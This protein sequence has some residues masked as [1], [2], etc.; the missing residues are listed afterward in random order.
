MYKKTQVIML[1]TTAVLVYNPLYICAWNADKTH[2]DVSEIAAEKSVIS[3]TFG[4]YLKR[5]GFNKST[6]EEFKLGSETRSVKKWIRQ[7]SIDEDSGSAFNGRFYNHFHDPTKAWDVAGLTSSWFW[8]KDGKSAVLWAVDDSSNDWRWAK[9]RDY[10]YYALTSTSVIDRSANFASTF[11]GLGQII[12]LIQDMAQPAHVRNDPHPADDSGWIPGLEYWGQK[13]PENVKAIA[14]STSTLIFPTVDLNVS[15]GGYAPIT[16]FFDTDQYDGTNPSNSLAQGLAEYTN[17][18][19]FSDDTIFYYAYPSKKTSVTIDEK[20]YEDFLNPGNFVK[21]QYYMKTA[22]GETGYRLA[23]VDYLNFY[24]EAYLDPTQQELVKT[25]GLMDDYVHE[26]YAKKLIPRAVGYSAGLVNYFFR[27]SLEIS[28]PDSYIYSITDGSA[29]SQ[30]FNQIKAKVKNTTSGES[31]GNGIIQAVAR[32]KNRRDYQPDLSTDPPL[33]RSRDADF[34]YSVSASIPITSLSSDTPTEFTFD[35]SGSPIPAGITDL[36]LHVVFK[37]TL[38][39]ETDNAIAVGM[40]DINEPMHISVWNATD[41][42]Y[43]DGVLRTAEEIRNDPTLLSRVD[44]NGDD[45]A[46]EYIDPYDITTKVAFAPTTTIPATY[47]AT[48]T[49]LPSGRYG[50]TIIITDAPAFYMHIHRESTIPYDNYN[51]YLL[52]SGVTNQENNGIFDNTQVYTFRGVTQHE[53][54]AY[55]RYYPYSTGISTAPW[56]APADIN[57]YPAT[58]IYP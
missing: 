48:Y 40:K 14:S 10:Y 25:I 27:G 47:N 45:T 21:R 50:R 1:L 22:D 4:D 18:N 38:G 11:K 43:L 13:H 7:G 39:S 37:G 23:A 52:F 33:A 58:T 28:A 57:P 53:W 3:G 56:P 34:S 54:S 46:E 20:E 8:I 29:T 31:I 17:A 49:P 44:H 32:Y 42:F 16:Q 35:F 2:N 24:R 30:Q 26:D 36:Y 19:F 55:S 5:L 12:H 51:T 15:N 41:R 9:V 6:E